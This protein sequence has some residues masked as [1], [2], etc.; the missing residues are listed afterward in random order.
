MEL[1]TQIDFSILY[2]IQ[3]NLKCGFLDF[4]MPCITMLGNAGI[5]WIIA[6]VLFL[7]FKKTRQNGI[8]MAAALLI[9]LLIGNLIIKN[10]VARDRPCWIDESVALL[11]A[12]PKDF[13]FPS[14]HTMHSFAAAVVIFHQDKRW[15]AGALAIAA[16]IGF[17]RLYLF[18]H[19][20]TDVLGGCII[21]IILGIA[22]FK[23][24]DIVADKIRAK[25]QAALLT[26]EK[27][28]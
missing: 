9:G 13:S 16:L 22:S 23:I 18:V 15:G 4:L 8:A 25:K 6:A 26:G 19:F 12:V 5:I 2:F 17:S 10:L 21:G 11:I 3:D 27:D 7:I 1:I 24:T 28:V 20:P 14:G